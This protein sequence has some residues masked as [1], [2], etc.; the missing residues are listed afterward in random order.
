MSSPK[1]ICI[2]GK[3]CCGKSTYAQKLRIENK[4]V[5]LSIDEITLSLFGQHLGDRHD[6]ITGKTQEYLLQKSVEIIETG[7]SVILD[8]GFWMKKRRDDVRKF[9]ADRGIASEFHYL[10]ISDDVWQERLCNRNDAVLAGKT[11][12]YFVDD[13]LAAKFERLFEA[14]HNDEIDIWVKQ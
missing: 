4:A 8:W 13:N 10:D 1:V 3:I 12:A 14:P 2:C 5:I 7:I 11:S 6:E 9:Y